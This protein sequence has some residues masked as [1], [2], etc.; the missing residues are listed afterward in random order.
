MHWPVLNADL[1]LSRLE[2]V[3]VCHCVLHPLLII[4]LGEV[5]SGMC[6]SALL[7]QHQPNI[8]K[9]GKVSLS[10]LHKHLRLYAQLRDDT[11]SEHDSV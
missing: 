10:A 4:P 2:V 1:V 5:L 9:Y 6:P 7:Q 3:K 11:C 8:S